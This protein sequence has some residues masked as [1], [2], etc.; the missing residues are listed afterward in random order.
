MRILFLYFLSAFVLSACNPQS[1]EA[2]PTLR[3]SEGSTGNT[4]IT[5]PSPTPAPTPIAPVPTPVPTPP[6]DADPTPVP[7]TP[8]PVPP[9]PTP[10]PPTPTPVPP[11]P[12]PVPT[13]DRRVTE[14]FTQAE[15]AGKVDILIIADN[16]ASMDKEQKKMASRFTN[17]ISAIKDLDYQ[18]GITTTDLSGPL[19]SGFATDGRLVNYTGTSEKILTP[20]TPNSEQL[21]LKTIQREETID[22]SSRSKPPYC[23]SGDEEPLRAMISAI[24][25]RATANLGFFRDTVDLAIVVLSD[26]DEMSDGTSPNTTRPGTVLNAFKAAF[27]DTKKMMVHGIIIQPGDKKCLKAQK[28]ES[29]SGNAGYYGNNVN[30]LAKSTGGRTY[31]ICA[32]DYGTNL[33]SISQDVRK[34][35]SSFELGAEPQPGS[36]VTVTLWPAAP[37]ITWRIENKLVVFSSPPPPGTRIEVRYI[38][39]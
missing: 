17:F 23:P 25:Q 12:T 24:D 8:T 5:A 20:K 14:S 22:C 9:T 37:Q 7:P 26:E 36:T 6:P 31:S 16:S 28:A 18:I 32:S 2:D 11:T 27:Q 39:K 33:S 29:P 1:F 15:N 19:G 3:Q 13:P 34:L 30:A 10:V 4:P 38:P 21:F 35:V